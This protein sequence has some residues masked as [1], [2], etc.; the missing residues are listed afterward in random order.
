MHWIQRIRLSVTRVRLLAARLQWRLKLEWDRWVYSPKC[1][2]CGAHADS[3]AY[4]LRGGWRFGRWAPH[5]CMGWLCKVCRE[6]PITAER[7]W[8]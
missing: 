7:Q 8:Q 2:S 3:E 6:R 1:L 4:A 5:T